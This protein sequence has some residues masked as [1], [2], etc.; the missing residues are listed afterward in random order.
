MLLD[1]A[2]AACVVNTCSGQWTR[3]DSK[4]MSDSGKDSDMKSTTSSNANKE[5]S[6]NKPDIT[7]KKPTKRERESVVKSAKNLWTSTRS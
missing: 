3:N 4:M 6:P 1:M 5:A 2:F 7:T